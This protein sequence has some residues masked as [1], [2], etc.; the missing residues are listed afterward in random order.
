VVKDALTATEAGGVT[1][2]HDP[3][4]GGLINGLWEL[5]EASG[6]GLIAHEERVPVEPETREICKV[7]NLDPLRIMSSGA[8]L[9]SSEPGK[10]DAILSALRE[11]GIPASIIGSVEKLGN[12]RR[13]IKSDGGMEG[14][15][16][17]PDHL[18]KVLEEGEAFHFKRPAP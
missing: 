5:A 16:P 8:L 2:L 9:I 17:T 10:A 3:T 4:E 15:A 6:V 14:I 12:G 1:A 7:L 18:Y 13:I 11:A